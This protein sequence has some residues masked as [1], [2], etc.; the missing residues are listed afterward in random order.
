MTP[1]ICGP[2]PFAKWPP[3]TKTSKRT[4]DPDP[5]LLS[6][7]FLSLYEVRNALWK[8]VQ[9]LWL[10]NRNMLVIEATDQRVRRS[11]PCTASTHA[12]PNIVPRNVMQALRE[13]ERERMERKHE[14]TCGPSYLPTY[15]RTLNTHNSN[16]VHAPHVFALSH[17]AAATLPQLRK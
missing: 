3:V 13:G 8:A 15:L 17:T 12:I 1:F 7:C 9:G 10:G 2:C 5:A 4:L 11:G 16:F 14:K 6:F